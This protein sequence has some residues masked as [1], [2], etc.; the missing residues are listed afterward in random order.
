MNQEERMQT[1]RL[2]NLDCADCARKIEDGLK[3][4]TFVR[5]V[6]VDFATLSM[7]IDTDDMN[8]VREKVRSIEPGVEIDLEG[9]DEAG[10][11]TESSFDLKRELIILGAGTLLF[12]AGAIFE[13][14]LHQVVGGGWIEYVVFGVAYLLVGWNVLLS[15]FRS[16]VKGRVFNEH[17]LMTIAT[18]GAFAI[19]ALTEAVAVMLFY[20]AGEILQEFSVA[21]SRRSIR[22]LLEL[23]PDFARVRRNGEWAEVKPEQVAAG[24]EINVRPGERIPLDGIVL[25]GTGFVDTSALTGE[26]VPRRAEP[27][28]EALAGTIS[29]DGSLTI[30]VTKSAGESSAA[31]IIQLVE[32]ATHAKSKTDRFI[33]RFARYYTPIVVAGAALVAFLPPLLLPGATFNDWIYRALVMLVV[34][35]PCALVVSIPLGY[36][37]GVGGASRHGI[38]VKGATYLDILAGVRTVVFDKTGTLTKGVFKVTRVQPLNGWTAQDLLRYAAF[39]EVHSNHPIAVSIREGYGLPVDEAVVHEY[40]EIGG[41]G[42][43]ARVDGH[44]VIAGND[45]LLHR[46][47]VEHEVCTIEGTVVH[48]AID[49]IYAGHLIISDELKDDAGKAIQGLG[50]IGVERTVLLTGDSREIAER[51]AAELGMSE[52]FGE[53]LPADKVAYL[54]R[55]MATQGRGARTAFVGDGINDAPVLARSDVG[56]AMG[57]FG[58][59]AAIETAD[60]VLMTDNPLKIVD[61]IR[62]GRKT[63]SIVTQNIVFALGVKAVVLGLGAVGVATM[64]EAVIADMGVALIAILNATRAMR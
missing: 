38:L 48:V 22:N 4:Q 2:K 8:R 13:S 64:W 25:A 45:R 19:H 28:K 50:A 62:R 36:F 56:I 37:G 6:S 32:N 24:D 18:G 39:A 58:S 54:E 31:K 1:C 51:T 10:E 47:K 49:G 40:R 3:G 43:T 17:F 53:L 23:R 57:Q 61:A 20:K 63:R 42:V 33:T 27:G 35:C 29:T 30:R 34:S 44:S 12:A 5:S 16:I 21:R 41:H 26:A 11:E 7:K 59:D 46:E 55:I 52:Y 15:A 60:V 9:E 14:R